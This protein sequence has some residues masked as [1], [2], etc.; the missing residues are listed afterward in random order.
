[1]F[2]PTGRN[3]SPCKDKVFSLQVEKILLAGRKR[4]EQSKKANK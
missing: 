1:M 2:I 3:T 4:V